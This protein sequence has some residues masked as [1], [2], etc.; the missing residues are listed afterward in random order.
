MEHLSQTTISNLNLVY[1]IGSLCLMSQGTNWERHNILFDQNKF[2]YIVDGECEIT[3]Q[4]KIYKGNAGDWFF[5]PAGTHHSYHNN[6]NKSF[7]LYYVHFDLYP[8]AKIVKQ[9]NIDYRVK[10]PTESK[11]NKLFEELVKVCESDQLINKIQAKSILFDLLAEYLDLA[12]CTNITVGSKNKESLQRAIAYINENLHQHITNTDLA[13]IAHMH[14][15]H[16]IR[17]FK[18]KTN[19]TPQNYIMLRR[20]ETAKQLLEQTTLSISE[21]AESTGFFDGSHF[22][23]SFRSV[24][25]MNPLQYRAYVKEKHSQEIERVKNYQNSTPT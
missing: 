15:N 25:D 18:S 2:Y 5:I 19:H 24:Y 10:V 16:F 7:G 9:L 1:R 6:S 3:I 8:D 17:Y 4:G 11:C 22:T 23:R 12:N 13:E 20:V 14:T 21:I